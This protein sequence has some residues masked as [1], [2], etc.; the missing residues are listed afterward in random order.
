[1][2]GNG[3]R[4]RFLCSEGPETCWQRNRRV[5]I[6]VIERLARPQ[7]PFGLGRSIRPWSYDGAHSR[8]RACD[9]PSGRYSGSG[10]KGVVGR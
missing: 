8:P 10:K 3:D 4:G 1:M 9:D 7:L 6:G 5:E 2:V